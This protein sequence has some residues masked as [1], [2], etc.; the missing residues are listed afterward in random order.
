MNAGR[1]QREFD[2]AVAA[3][4]EAALLARE[5]RDRFDQRAF[6]ADR[7]PVTVADFAVQTIVAER[8]CQ[9]VPDDPLVAEEDSAALRDHGS[10]PIRQVMLDALRPRVSGLSPD[11]LL[12]RIDRGRGTP[13]PR[14][15]TLDPVDN[16]PGFIRGDQYPVAL[17]DRTPADPQR[18]RDRVEQAPARRSP[19][20]PFGNP[21]L[22]KR[23]RHGSRA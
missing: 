10:G 7:S 9:V 3:V 16:T 11:R 1:W 20:S 8:L 5:I 13:G 23:C 22:T 15:W 21:R 17:R 12:G 18:G 19:E 6:K 14:F 4:R 2:L